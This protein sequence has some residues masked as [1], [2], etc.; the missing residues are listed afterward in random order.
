MAR[1]GKVQMVARVTGWLR[2]TPGNGLATLL[3]REIG[4]C[5]DPREHELVSPR[6]AVDKV[7]WAL[8]RQRVMITRD[9]THWTL[10]PMDVNLPT[11]KLRR[12]TGSE[13]T[14]AQL[15]AEEAEHAV[16]PA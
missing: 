4:S 16:A 1:K 2:L 15:A 5:V 14:A 9:D 7:H 10:R 8:K 3:V 11:M 12:V 6:A 13:L